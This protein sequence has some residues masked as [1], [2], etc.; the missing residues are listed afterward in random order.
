METPFALGRKI[1]HDPRSRRFA[2][3]APSVPIVAKTW[4]RYGAVLDQGQLGSCTGNAMAHALNSKPNHPVG[5]S[6]L[7]QLQAVA[8]YSLGTELDEFDGVYPPE[9][10]G[11]SGLGVAKAAQKLGYIRSYQHAFGFDHVI[12]SLM[13]GPVLIGTW[14]HD[15]M[16][17]PDINGFVRPT[18]TRVGGHE[19]LLVGIEPAKQT[20]LFQNSWSKYWGLGGR[21]KMTFDDFRTLLAADGDALIPII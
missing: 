11:S 10:T 20:L 18:G 16:F 1:E 3:A 13:A 9:D 19:Y 6:T 7:R 21:F 14:W 17:Y 15:G 2:F 12:A 5:R 8:I 4:R